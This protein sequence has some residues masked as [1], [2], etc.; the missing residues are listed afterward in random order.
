MRI[1]YSEKLNYSVQVT[2]P[3]FILVQSPRSIHSLGPARC[4]E[5]TQKVVAPRVEITS[6]ESMTCCLSLAHLHD[7][8]T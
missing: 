6:L 1:Q 3:L 7:P 8:L 4:M 2:Q 5:E